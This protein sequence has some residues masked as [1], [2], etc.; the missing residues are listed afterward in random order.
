MSMEEKQNDGRGG[1]RP[2][3]GRPKGITKPYKA[4]SIK[5]PIEYIDK[6]K[7]A[8]DRQGLSVSRFIQKAVDNAMQSEISG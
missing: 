5:L 4:F 3:A 7:D 1:K 6:I 2:G 8:A